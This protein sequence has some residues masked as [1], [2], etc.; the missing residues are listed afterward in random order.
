MINVSLPIIFYCSLDNC[1]FRILL[2]SSSFNQ[3][4]QRL[5][6]LFS[7][8]ING[9]L[10]TLYKSRLN[11]NVISSNG[12]NFNNFDRAV[13]HKENL[14]QPNNCQVLQSEGYYANRSLLIFQ[15]EAGF[16]TKYSFRISG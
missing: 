10:Y 14:K 6:D 12:E 3:N 16:H 9:C 5:V 13:H 7:H 4:F 11:S 1:K 2:I 8:Q 15:S